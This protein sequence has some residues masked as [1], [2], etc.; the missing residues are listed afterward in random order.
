LLNGRSLIRRCAQLLE[1]QHFSSSFS[2]SPGE[3]RFNRPRARCEFDD[4]NLLNR[5]ARKAFAKVRKENQT[6]SRS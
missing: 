4:T 5:K 2:A 6:D 1:P 3:S